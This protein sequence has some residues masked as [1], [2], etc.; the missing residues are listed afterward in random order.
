MNEF[1]DSDYAFARAFPDVFLFGTAYGRKGGALG[2]RQ[3]HHLLSQF[4]NNAASCI[5]LI[6]YLFDKKQRYESIKG[7][8]TKVKSNKKD[9]KKFA[10]EIQ[11]KEFQT[12][13][14]DAV[15]NPKSR[16]AKKVLKKILPVLNV[17]GKKTCFGAVE[18]TWHCR[19]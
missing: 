12:Q 1:K 4:T 3:R 13:L 19:G 6:F 18:K 15:A 17:A 16:N 10:K 9:F 5:P 2:M 7:I 11:S 14:R 8:S